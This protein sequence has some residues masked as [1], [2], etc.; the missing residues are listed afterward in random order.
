MNSG[1]GIKGGLWRGVS[2]VL[3]EPCKAGWLEGR[4]AERAVDLQL[5]QPGGLMENR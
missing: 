3:G 1:A 4:T 5:V 2:R